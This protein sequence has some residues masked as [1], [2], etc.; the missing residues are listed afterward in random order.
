MGKDAKKP[1]RN[2]NFR[3]PERL[4]DRLVVSAKNAGR[5]LSEELERR[6]IDSFAFEDAK[7]DIES[8]K[9]KAAAALDAA[10]VMAIRA[11]GLTILREIEGRPTRA[12]PI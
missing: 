6:V 9:T 11:A 10:N 4:H 2:F 1:R 8:M 12:I 7:V 5:S 3:L